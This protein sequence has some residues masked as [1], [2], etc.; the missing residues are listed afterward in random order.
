MRRKEE[1]TARIQE[2][3]INE[4]I[5]KGLISASM[6]NISKNADVSKRTLYKY[7]PNKDK[8]FD[9][10]VSLLLDSV[11]GLSNIC[12]SSEISIGEQLQDIIDT[13]IDLLTSDDYVKISKLVLSELI[14]SRPLSEKHFNQF[15]ESEQTFIRWIDEAKKD[16]KITSKD[17]SELMANQFHSIIKG[18]IF[19]PVI[20][21]IKKLTKND[22]INSK[23]T[24]KEFFLKSFCH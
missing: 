13:K 20:F 12:Y 14:K 15:S 24:A 2:S 4:F 1:I 6:E 22:I 7:Y 5:L 19:Y 10:I 9:D 21:G 23:K 11:C 17:P 18:Q 3:A 16:G 8:I